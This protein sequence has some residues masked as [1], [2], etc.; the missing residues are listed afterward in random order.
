MQMLNGVCCCWI[1]QGDP[2][3]LIVNNDN[4]IENYGLNAVC[5]HLGCVVPW[6]GVSN[7]SWDALGEPGWLGSSSSNCSSAA[8]IQQLITLGQPHW[9]SVG[10]SIS[11]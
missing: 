7:A 2:T 9:A 5:T 1:A 3:Y 11:I 4:A 6:V 8:V 10:R